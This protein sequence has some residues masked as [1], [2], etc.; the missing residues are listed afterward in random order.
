MQWQKDKGCS[1]KNKGCSDLSKDESV[2]RCVQSGTGQ[3]K[4]S[5]SSLNR[6]SQLLGTRVKFFGKGN[7]WQFKIVQMAE[8]ILF[9]SQFQD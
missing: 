9:K 4:M 7:D 5:P 2:K 6:R 8:A 1:E 3:T